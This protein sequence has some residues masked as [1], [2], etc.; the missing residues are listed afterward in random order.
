[1]HENMPW[2]ANLMQVV[3]KGTIV[4][5]HQ[6]IVSSDVEITF[7]D[8][9]GTVYI[10]DYCNIASKVKIIVNKGSVFIDDWTS[11]HESCLLLCAEN[12]KIGQHCWFGQHCVLDGTAGL[13][14]GNSVRVGMYSQIWSHVAA[15]E[16]FEG[17]VLFS[18]KPVF[19][20]DNV[21]LVGSCICSPGVTIKKFATALS[22]SVITKSIREYEVVAGS[23]ASAKPNMC[24]YQPIS[25]QAKFNMVVQWLN[26]FNQCVN[27]KYKIL[28]N[29][30][31]ICISCSNESI[32]FF[33][34]N[35]SYKKSK[36]DNS[37]SQNVSVN[38]AE[39]IYT[40]K[41][42][43]LEEALFKFLSNNKVRFLRDNCT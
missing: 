4:V 1:M 24:F 19:I 35:N 18:E 22:Q 16:Q 39:K 8:S 27:G 6:S 41:H 15:G 36:I 28:V 30:D 29:E 9:E 20:E 11:I 38:L 13:T 37:L 43:C 5:G 10:G 2:G 7:L 17:C 23:P 21:W 33:C 14:I 34:S 25:L 3:G 26:E 42:T 32:E 31:Y 12:L 40:K